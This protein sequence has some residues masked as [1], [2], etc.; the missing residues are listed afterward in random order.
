MPQPRRVLDF[1]FVNSMAWNAK[2][3]IDGSLITENFK[4][5][6]HTIA[7]KLQ[8]LPSCNGWTFWYKSEKNNLVS[9][10]LLREKARSELKQT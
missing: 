9:I 1:N 7:A 4:G 5:S 6:I 3:K 10:D 2:V 8:N